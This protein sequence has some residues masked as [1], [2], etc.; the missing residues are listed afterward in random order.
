MAMI[1]IRSVYGPDGLTLEYFQ[2]VFQGTI[3]NAFTNSIVVSLLSAFI[4]TALGFIVA[5]TV[6]YTNIP[7][8]AKKLL[9][10]FMMLPMFLPTIT[11]GFAIIFSYGPQGLWRNLLPLPSFNIYGIIG[12][13][14][15][16]V[17]YTL[18][19]SFL[20][21]NNSMR[22]TDRRL[23]IVSELL[24]D[25]KLRMFNNT[26][27]KPIIPA[28]VTSIIQ[29][30]FL[31]F[32]D[33]G[34]PTSLGGSVTLISDLLYEQM[35]GALPSFNRGAVI[36][37]VMLLPAVVSVILLAFVS[38]RQMVSSVGVTDFDL[39]ED[40]VRDSISS[41]LSILIVLY[42]LS[43][44]IVVIIVPFVQSWPYNIRFTLDH[45]QSVFSD[46]QLIGTYQNSL[47]IAFFTAIIGTIV[48]Y[49]SAL[50]TARRANLS[51]TS[52]FVTLMSALV[53]TIPGMVLGIAYLLTFSGT[54]LQGTFTILIV[55]NIVHYFATPYLT[56]KD[57]LSKLNQNWEVT[58]NLLGDGWFKSVFKILIPNTSATLVEVFAYYFINGMVTVSAVI[59]LISPRTTLVTT[60]IKELQYF[61]SHNE[62]F[63]LSLLILV[64]N[65]FIY[66]LSQSFIRR[67]ENKNEI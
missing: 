17:I 31:S 51:K 27:L 58:A 2:Q 34:I 20:L 38:R 16:F 60:K 9:T 65:L 39:G 15:G 61:G 55:S 10:F 36:A 1:F 50:F 46:S 37:L 28:F 63:V 45:F 59:F 8:W 49:S 40:K 26:I 4:T 21:I 48:A 32:T 57:S 42:L 14:M 7:S 64:T 52:S 54:T 19:V 18:P 23:S 24:G 53:N 6:N 35:M 47:T 43:I 12:L 44:F 41:L 3:A 25:S 33:F 22:Y 29:C 66:A 67:K 56:F 5:F 30:F 13:T 62:I 11:Y